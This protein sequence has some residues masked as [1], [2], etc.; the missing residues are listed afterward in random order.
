MPR[1]ITT[2]EYDKWEVLYN[3]LNKREKEYSKSELSNARFSFINSAGFATTSPLKCI[4]KLIN[5]FKMNVESYLDSEYKERVENLLKGICKKITDPS[6][7]KHINYLCYELE[8]LANSRVND[9][10][11]V[12]KR[13]ESWTDKVKLDK[14]EKSLITAIFEA[15]NHHN[16]LIKHPDLYLK[17]LSRISDLDIPYYPIKE[18][19]NSISVFKRL[20]VPQLFCLQYLCSQ[21]FVRTMDNEKAKVQKTSLDTSE[22]QSKKPKTAIVPTDTVKS[23][24]EYFESLG[25]NHY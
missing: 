20:C 5:Y 19:N 23:K 12:F 24:I 13:I 16:S 15:S 7:Y 18:N 4:D 22:Y 1:L 17:E 3:I 10:E 25:K 8:I 9:Q 11:R 14:D 6:P 21:D 2:K